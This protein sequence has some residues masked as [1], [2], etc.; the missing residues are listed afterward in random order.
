MAYKYLKQHTTTSNAKHKNRSTIFIL[1]QFPTTEG[2]WIH[3]GNEFEQKW[4]FPNWV[5]LTEST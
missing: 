4:D 1:L 5:P 2:E 3:V